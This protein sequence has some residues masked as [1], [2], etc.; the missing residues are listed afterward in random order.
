MNQSDHDYIPN[1]AGISILAA[2]EQQERT[3]EQLISLTSLDAKVVEYH[4]EE[5][6]QIGYIHTR[7]SSLTK[8]KTC[9][10]TAEGRAYVRHKTRKLTES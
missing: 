3:T 5:M 4:V 2:L 9:S 8:I 10:I 1:E 7:Y 6:F